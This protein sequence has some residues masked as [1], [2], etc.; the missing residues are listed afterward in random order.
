MK[1]ILTFVLL[2]FLS[3]PVFSQ[4]NKSVIPGYTAVYSA[5]SD[6]TRGNKI[7]YFVKG[8][9]VYASDQFN[10]VTTR[11]MR[12]IIGDKVYAADANTGART[13][14]IL[15]Y[16]VDNKVYAADI[17]T[18]AR[19]NRILNY[20]DNNIVYAADATTGNRTDRKLRFI[21]GSEKTD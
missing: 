10:N 21:E 19:T 13:A 2:A 20:I 18:R 14:T 16:I 5:S 11:V 17:T 15:Y 1:S 3:M 12:Y 8:G 4:T 6:G 7:L 9:I